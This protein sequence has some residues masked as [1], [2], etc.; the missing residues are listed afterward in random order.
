VLCGLAIYNFT[1][2][3]VPFP[4][5][6]YKK[7]LNEVDSNGFGPD[8][9]EGLSPVVAKG[10]FKNPEAVCLFIC[11]RVMNVNEAGMNFLGVLLGSCELDRHVLCGTTVFL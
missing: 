9:L 10:K 1:I 7:L 6:L 4:L 3:N 8:D 5:A 11:E 2:I